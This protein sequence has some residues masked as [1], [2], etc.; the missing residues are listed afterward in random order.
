V[1]CARFFGLLV[2]ALLGSGCVVENGLPYDQ[3]SINALRGDGSTVTRYPKCFT[4][5]V[6]HGSVVEER[7]AIEGGVTIV[8]RA[9]DSVIEVGFEGVT[10]P[11]GAKRS[12]TLD[13]LEAAY[14]ETLTIESTSG[15]PFSVKLAKGC[16]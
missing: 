10:D 7:H 6:L 11:G 14:A 12:I 15:A 1:S 4:M 8:I 16:R 2:G 13:E 3:L 5:P 9:T